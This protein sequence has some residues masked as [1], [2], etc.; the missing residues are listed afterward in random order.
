MT[1]KKIHISYKWQL[2][3]IAQKVG[4]HAVAFK[5]VMF[6]WGDN[7]MSTKELNHRDFKVIEW[8]RK[9]AWIK[10]FLNISDQCHCQFFS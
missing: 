7:E 3:F 4:Q 9:V 1:A 10:Y 2:Y 8:V 5:S 6:Y